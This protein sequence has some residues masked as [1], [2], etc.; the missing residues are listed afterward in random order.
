MSNTRYSKQKGLEGANQAVA[1]VRRLWPQVERRVQ[2]GAKDR[3]DIAG[4]PFVIEVKRT[5]R[6]DITKYLS[7]LA[8]ERAN[9][10]NKPGFVMVRRNRGPWTFIVPEDTMLELL[11]AYKEAR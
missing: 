3:G 1:W 11:E 9:D 10:S 6:W 8:A 5:E 4:T 7:E 2:Y